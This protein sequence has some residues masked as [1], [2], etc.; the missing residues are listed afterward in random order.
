[1]TTSCVILEVDASHNEP[2]DENSAAFAE[3][4]GDGE[5]KSRLSCAQTSDQQNCYDHKHMFKISR[6]KN[7][8]MA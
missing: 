4:L 2:P 1:M 7:C 6:L 8:Y 3:V 5:E